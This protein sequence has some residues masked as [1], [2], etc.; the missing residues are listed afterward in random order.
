MQGLCTRPPKASE[1][2]R[3]PKEEVRP[4]HLGSILF[5]PETP[6]GFA[7][8]KC[9]DSIRD[10]WGEGIKGWEP[11]WEVQASPSPAL[12]PLTLL[13]ACGSPGLKQRPLA[14][15]Y[16]GT[17]RVSAW[18]VWAQHSASTL[19]RQQTASPRRSGLRG[20]FVGLCSNL[21]ACRIPAWASAISRKLGISP[22]RGES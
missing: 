21:K 17:V 8:D 9:V 19:E 14:L 3:S 20:E 2:T 12:G 5:Y 7:G 16:G 1:T 22:E 13:R 4:S 6:V 15:G 10:V 11:L 18:N